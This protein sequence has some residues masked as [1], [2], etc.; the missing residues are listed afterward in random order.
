MFNKST[1]K[2]FKF[3]GNFFDQTVTSIAVS[4]DNT[5][6]TNIS[7]D[8][9]IKLHKNTT[10]FLFWLYNNL[11]M[12]VILLFMTSDADSTANEIG[13]K[14]RDQ[15]CKFE[16]AWINQP[17]VRG[18]RYTPLSTERGLA[19]MLRRS[20]TRTRTQVQ[21]WT[22]YDHKLSAINA[23]QHLFIYYFAETKTIFIFIKCKILSMFI[24]LMYK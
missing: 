10:Y 1:G 5:L 18:T 6:F 7:N 15:P 24:F 4:L 11:Y 9:H 8:K 16:P 19:D 17:A 3:T 21:T 20:L 2:N 13:L 14:Q 12:C 23:P 22:R